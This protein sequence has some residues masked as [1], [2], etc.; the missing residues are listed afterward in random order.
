MRRRNNCY[1]LP[2]VKL[3]ESFIGKVQAPAPSIRIRSHI[4]LSLCGCVVHGRT[5]SLTQELQ[6]LPIMTPKQTLPLARTN[7]L[8]IQ[9]VA[10][11]SL[12][13]DESSHEAHC[14]NQTA[15]LVWRHC[16]GRTTVDEMVAILHRTLGTPADPAVVELAL[17]QLQHA[18][19]VDSRAVSL[20]GQAF[21]SRRRLLGRLST[22]GMAMALAPLVTSVMTRTARAQASPKPTTTTTT[23]TTTTSVPQ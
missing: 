20:A 2:A 17:E 22:A 19:L 16:D 5:R 1:R 10:K 4:S 18:G 3:G 15:A 9:N 12:I 21:A 8:V 14:L 13:Y 11:E 6:K 7:N 23:T